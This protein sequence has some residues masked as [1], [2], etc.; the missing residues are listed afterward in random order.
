[1]RAAISMT[2]WAAVAL[3]TAAV[4]H[5]AD[6]QLATNRTTFWIKAFIPDQHPTLLGALT[7]ASDGKTVVKAPRLYGFD[8]AGRCFSTDNR[9]SSPEINAPARLHHQFD[10]VITGRQ[11]IIENE[12]KTVGPT[13]LVDCDTGIIERSDSA[14]RSDMTLSVEPGQGLTRTVNLSASSGNPFFVWGGVNVAPKIDWSVIIEYDVL[15]RTYKVI[16]KHGCF[17]AFEMYARAE[18]S[19]SVVAIFQDDIQNECTPI[20]LIDAGNRLNTVGDDWGPVSV[21][22]ISEHTTIIH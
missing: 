20:N 9:S 22:G 1:M 7:K 8:V 4:P 5:E 21:K 11:L 2:L 12:I 13:H 19:Q 17:P 14:P 18:G 6:S 15:A 10:I 3:V 16:Y